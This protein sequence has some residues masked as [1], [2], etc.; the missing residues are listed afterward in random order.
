MLYTHIPMHLHIH[1][2]TS[3]PVR[4]RACSA[5]RVPS[6]A[7]QCKPRNRGAVGVVVAVARPCLRYGQAGVF[8][9]V[10]PSRGIQQFVPMAILFALAARAQ[11][12]PAREPPRVAPM[13]APTVDAPFRH[14]PSLRP[15]SLLL[16]GDEKAF[17]PCF[18]R[19]PDIQTN[20]ETSRNMRKY[21]SRENCKRRPERFLVTPSSSMT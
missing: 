19:F 12:W 3:V 5:M 1:M 10:R 6:A 14:A 20:N 11:A 17:G 16:A 8:R 18:H 2:Y 15:A 9:G 13:A 7:P 4:M 21:P